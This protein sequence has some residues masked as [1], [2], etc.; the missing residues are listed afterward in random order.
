MSH[1][2]QAK[3]DKLTIVKTQLNPRSPSLL[4]FGH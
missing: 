4:H 2:D 1:H 3:A